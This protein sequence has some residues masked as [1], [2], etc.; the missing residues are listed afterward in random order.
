MEQQIR[1][2]NKM[3]VMPVGRLLISMSL[4]A[5]ISM[6]IQALYNIVDSMFVARISEDA[7]TAVSLAFPVQQMMISFSVGTGVG[8]N[9]LISRRLGE[10]RLEEANS[11]ASHGL[12]LAL[13]TS[14]AFALFGI[15]GSKVFFRAFTEDAGII[16]MGSAYTSICTILSFGVFVQICCERILQATGNMIYPMIMQ[17][18]GAIIN[19]ILDPIMIFGYFGL[20]AMGVAG[21]AWATVIGQI[22]AMVLSLYL[23]FGKEHEVKVRLKGFRFQRKTVADIYRVGLPSIIMQSIGSV[24]VVGM[25]KILIAFSTT[26][27]AVFGAYFKLQSFV[28][29]PV[30]GLTN[31]AMPIMGY[32]FGAANKKRLLQTL[33]YTLLFAI[34]ILLVGTLIFQLFPVPLLRLF[35]ASPEMLEMGSYALRIISLA[36]VLAA[37]GISFSTLFQAIGQGTKS[38]LMSLVRQLFAILPAA[39]ILG[40]AAGLKAIW[41]AFPISEVISLIALVF[42]FLSAYNKSIRNLGREQ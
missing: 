29:M 19:I 36:F 35:D 39:Y 24:M 28:F 20:P 40:K 15:F 8:I 30:F 4:P 1:K 16:Q 2:E 21:A 22:A 10:R 6:I 26:A 41:F 33:R 42:L 25:N 23:V 14:L 3:G 17:L 12:A 18:T 27:V 37:I 34:S 11:A 7:L 5:M 32:N 31:G 13:V 38:M 9:S